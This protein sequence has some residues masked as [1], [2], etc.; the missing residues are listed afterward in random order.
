[1]TNFMFFFLNTLYIGLIQET[2]VKDFEGRDFTI[3]EAE[4]TMFW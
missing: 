4:K 1:M 3:L 2:V